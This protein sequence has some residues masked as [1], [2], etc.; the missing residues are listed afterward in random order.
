MCR[1]GCVEQGSEATKKGEGQ[2]RKGEIGER[3]EEIGE[4]RG[5]SGSGDWGEERASCFLA[6]IL[7]QACHSLAGCQL[8]FWA[9][10][11]PGILHRTNGHIKHHANKD[12]G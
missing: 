8:G 3:R 11:R 9:S 1:E 4:G 5:R 7:A 10:L 6:S 2:E 12:D